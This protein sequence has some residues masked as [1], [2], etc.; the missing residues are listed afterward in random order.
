MFRIFSRKK[1]YHFK[2]LRKFAL[3]FAHF[4]CR[5]RRIFLDLFNLDYSIN[6][7]G[8]HTHTQCATHASLT[9][10]RN[11]FSYKYY[12]LSCF[13]N[14]KTFWRS[15]R[16]IHLNLTKSCRYFRLDY[17]HSFTQIF[18]VYQQ[19]IIVIDKIFSLDTQH[20]NFL[21]P[22]WAKTLCLCATFIRG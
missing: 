11:K 12:S 8:T 13:N 20:L 17:Q 19:K 18:Q 10:N 1:S 21:N 2:V 22:I 7:W 9:H 15:S 6:H 5:V 16:F 14:S 4:F 3:E